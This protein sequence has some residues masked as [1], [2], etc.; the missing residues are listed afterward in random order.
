MSQIQNIGIPL[1]DEALDNLFKKTGGSKKALTQATGA[2]RKAPRLD[3][4]VPVCNAFTEFAECLRS[5]L[6]HTD[7]RHTIWLFDDCSDDQRVKRFVKAL[8]AK[9]GQIRYVTSPRRLGFV[10]NVNRAIKTTTRT[11]VLLNSDTIVTNGWLDRLWECLRQSSDIGIVSPLSN[12]GSFLSVTPTDLDHHETDKIAEIVQETSSGTSIDIPTAVGFCMLVRRSVVDEI[13]LLD[14]AFSPGYGEEVDF[15]LRAWSA[16]WRSQVCTSSFVYHH[17]NKSFDPDSSRTFRSR[18]ERLLESRWPSY[19][20]IVR[21]WWKYNPLRTQIQGI[22][23]YRRTRPLIVHLLHRWNTIGGTEMFATRLIDSLSDEFN[24]LIIAPHEGADF[25]SDAISFCL[26][27]GV[28]LL[29][30]N[31]KYLRE[32]IEILRAPSGLRNDWIDGWFAR[33]LESSHASLLH[34]HHILGWDSLMPP[35]IA[36]RLGIPVI[37]SLH[38]FYFLC[39]DYSQIGPNRRPCKKPLIETQGECINCIKEKTKSSRSYEM[40]ELQRYVGLRRMVAR[41]IMRISD[42][43][44]SPSKFLGDRYSKAFG[45][46]FSRRLSIIP[47]S[48]TPNFEATPV[49]PRSPLILGY[50]GGIKPLKGY[51]TLLAAVNTPAFRGKVKVRIYGPDDPNI[52]PKTEGCPEVEWMGPYFPDQINNIMQDIDIVVLPSIFEESFSLNLSEAW[53]NLRPAITSDAGV[54]PERVQQA[55][56][57]WT[58]QAGNALKLRALIQHLLT[59]A[60]LKEVSQISSHLLAKREKCG[61]WSDAQYRLIYR[62]LLESSGQ[63]LDAGWTVNSDLQID[64]KSALGGLARASPERQIKNS[65]RTSGPTRF[66]PPLKVWIPES[67]N[68]GHKAVKETQLSLSGQEGVDVFFGEAG[69]SSITAAGE[70]DWIWL[71]HPYEKALNGSIEAL[72]CSLS[73]VREN[74]TALCFDHI[75]HS[76]SEQLH[77]LVA[78]GAW[79]PW[80]AWSTTTFDSGWIIRA[81]LLQTVFNEMDDISDWPRGFF[82]ELARREH[83]I[84]SIPLA[85]VSRPD[86]PSLPF[87]QAHKKEALPKYIE[88]TQQSVTGLNVLVIGPSTRDGLEHTVRSIIQFTYRINQVYTDESINVEYLTPDLRGGIKFLKSSVPSS[89]SPILVIRAGVA[90]SNVETVSGYLPVF[91]DPDVAAIGF[92][93]KGRWNEDYAA[94]HTYGHSAVRLAPFHHWSDTEAHSVRRCSVL[95]FDLALVRASHIDILRSL[96]SDDNHSS[97][98][99]ATSALAGSWINT[100]PAL[101]QKTTESADPFFSPRLSLRS[102][103]LVPDS[104]FMQICSYGESRPRVLA[105]SSASTSSTNYRVLGPLNALSEA[106]EIEPAIFIEMGV[107]FAISDQELNRISPDIIML[108]G[109]TG[110]SVSHLA[111]KYVTV[112]SFDDLIVDPPR[113]NVFARES[114]REIRKWTQEALV[115][116]DRIVVSTKELGTFLGVEQRKVQVIENAINGDEW[117]HANREIACTRNSEKLRVVWAGAQQHEGDLRLIKEVVRATSDIAEWIFFGMCPEYLKP[118][119][120]EIVTPVPFDKYPKALLDLRMDVGVAPLVDNPFNR[121]KSHLK[122]LEYGACGAAVIASDLPPYRGCPV[123]LVSE[124]A[125]D[126]IDAINLYAERPSLAKVEGAALRKWVMKGQTIDHR[127]NEWRGLTVA[128]NIEVTE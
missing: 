127:L 38:C 117:H 84:R 79:D 93:T 51:E 30:W 67:N 75:F 114:S 40:H 8:L 17:G 5:L 16:G 23:N 36:K 14:S 89:S 59:G 47:H 55:V 96:E 101:E 105:I 62:S 26:K 45:P 20:T 54:F 60:G 6:K 42:S 13:G 25:W 61:G 99:L 119:A 65:W 109:Y 85:I 43:I 72:L 4:I 124:R 21:N 92:G 98:L 102:A 64:L 22:E 83:E 73:D 110:I 32:Q 48:H 76:E 37:T 78:K 88:T 74:I 86:C 2:P 104:S 111:Q 58:F 69:I 9:N 63:R 91:S 128:E 1:V 123:R 29:L 3:I 120:R 7:P 49:V 31:R 103:N 33:V 15:C 41:Q 56:N 50:F 70:S 82:R 68:A 24:H 112:V 19:E 100:P 27:P 80:L 121:S 90:L 108:H 115:H 106:G 44:I 113:Y 97:V 18:H 46:G 52:N 71:L 87:A 28:N 122:I 35:F 77:G 12:N 39:P 11:F 107:D 57:G 94:Q 66:N 34:I 53:G 95:T 118:F 126:W 116:A 81:E 125:A 10:E